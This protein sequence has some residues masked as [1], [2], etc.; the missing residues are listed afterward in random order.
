MMDE[1]MQ[2][3]YEEKVKSIMALAKKKKNVLEY[4]E[5]QDHFLELVLTEEQFARVI[6]TLEASGV[7]VLRI[8]S[9]DD[10]DS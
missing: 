8:T 4:S 6:E 9:G 1:A 10:D 5:I 2:A 3:K 7:D